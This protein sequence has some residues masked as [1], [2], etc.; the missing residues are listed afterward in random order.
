MNKLLTDEFDNDFTN[1]DYYC[2]LEVNGQ[3]STLR[4]FIKEL[5]VREVLK[6]YKQ[7]DRTAIEN[8]LMREISRRM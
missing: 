5:D 4:E 3:N 2:Q 6:L 1:Y 8:I 7:A